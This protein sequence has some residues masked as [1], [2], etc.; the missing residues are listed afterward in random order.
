MC[1]RAATHES[2][3]NRA[4]HIALKI[5]RYCHLHD[6]EPPLTHTH[7]VGKMVEYAP[8]PHQS[9]EVWEEW[10]HFSISGTP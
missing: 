4:L 6:H 10:A 2:F 5:A 9:S 1:I 7:F 3:E 8:S